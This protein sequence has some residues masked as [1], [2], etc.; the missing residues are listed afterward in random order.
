M[1]GITALQILHEGEVAVVLSV[2]GWMIL[3]PIR[4][5]IEKVKKPLAEVTG[6]LDEVQ[7]EL[8]TQRTNHLSHIEKSNDRQVEILREVSATLK[9]MHLDQRTMLGRLDK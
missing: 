3:F 2:G 4:T 5:L 8:T 6:K 7:D 9:E 1:L